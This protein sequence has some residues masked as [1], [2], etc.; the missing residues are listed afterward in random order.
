MA[1]LCG[2]GEGLDAELVSFWLEEEHQEGETQAV[3]RDQS[4]AI[5]M[6]ALGMT[7]RS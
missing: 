3:S 1:A 4:A 5:T 7:L 6:I 2:A